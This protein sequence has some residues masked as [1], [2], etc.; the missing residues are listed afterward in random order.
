MP[1]CSARWW[2]VHCR[3]DPCEL[4]TFPLNLPWHLAPD[5]AA[6][7]EA[8]PDAGQ[9]CGNRMIADDA[10]EVFRHRSNVVLLEIGGTAVERVGNGLRGG[11]HRTFLRQ[12]FA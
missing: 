6:E 4:R 11:P 2:S 5:G 7:E 12:M 9:Q 1:S 8:E 10:L 3:S